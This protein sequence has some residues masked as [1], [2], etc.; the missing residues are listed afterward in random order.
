[1]C[2]YFE[3]KRSSQKNKCLSLISNNFF[4]PYDILAKECGSRYLSLILVWFSVG[5]NSNPC[6][7]LHGTC[8]YC[9]AANASWSIT[10]HYQCGE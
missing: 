9:I 3:Q 7:C 1:M 6:C 2:E 8:K 5:P 10:Q 4:F